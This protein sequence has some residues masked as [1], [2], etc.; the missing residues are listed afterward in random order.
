MVK[1]MS[2]SLYI[3]DSSGVLPKDIM[4]NYLREE[5]EE[6]SLF[7]ACLC[8]TTFFLIGNF[9]FCVRY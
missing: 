2:A 4:P 1:D 7:G 5:I 8:I 6:V 3:S 9:I